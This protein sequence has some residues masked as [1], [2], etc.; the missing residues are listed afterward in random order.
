MATQQLQ[1]TRVEVVRHNRVD[2][3]EE[4]VSQLSTEH[5]KVWYLAD[6]LYSMLGDFAPYGELA[7]LLECYPKLH[8]YID[9]AHSTSWAGLH[10]RGTALSNLGGHDR[11]IVA[12]SLNKAFS[13]AGGA[14]ALPNSQMRS[15]IRRCGGPML[16]SGPIQPALL[17]AAVA[18]A[19]LHL[20]EPFS[21]IQQELAVRI[22]R[23][24]SQLAKHDVPLATHASSPIFM[25]QCDSPQRAFSIVQ[26]LKD[27]GF[28][29]CP[30]VFP[31]VPM[32][33]PSIRFALSRHNRLE[34]IDTFAAVMGRAVRN[35]AAQPRSLPPRAVQEAV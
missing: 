35:A 16:F 24:E 11:A 26:E 30:S 4:A 33:K 23:A 25:V 19:Q 32:N 1:H 20:S 34:D 29:C 27:A 5:D 6:G 2:R 18:S 7:R 17:G 9:D 3:L 8:L 22:E 12:L 13:A 14:L 15:L 10:G 21:G 31:A 28:Y